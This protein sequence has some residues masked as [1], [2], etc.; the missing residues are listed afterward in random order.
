MFYIEHHA[1][2]P[3]LPKTVPSAFASNIKFVKPCHG[4]DL[5]PSSQLL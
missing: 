5:Q 1:N 2:D 4:D 3:E